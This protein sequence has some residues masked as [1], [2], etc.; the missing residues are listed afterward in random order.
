MELPPI[1]DACCSTRSFWFD[2]QDERAM[3]MDKRK[4]ECPIKADANHPARNLVINP[5]IVADFT[6][7]P[8]PDESFY[9]VVFDPPHIKGTESRLNGVMGKTYGLLFP[10]WETMLRQGF[11][12]CFR[13]LKPGGTLIFKWC[14]LEIPVSDVLALTP[15]KP[16]FGHKS[17]KRSQTH[18]IAFGKAV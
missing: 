14:E 12:E 7:M 4:E 5:D 9:L 15:Q 13:V 8:F 18:W 10:G 3:F 17:G 16:L 1:L 11:E 2:K 6:D